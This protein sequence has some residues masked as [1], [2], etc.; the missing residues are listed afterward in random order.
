MKTICQY[1]CEKCDAVYNT[2]EQCEQCERKHAVPVSM[3]VRGG[4]YKVNNTYPF[5]IYIKMDDGE[6]IPFYSKD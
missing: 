4:G 1:V 5:R 2:K 3:E 6:V